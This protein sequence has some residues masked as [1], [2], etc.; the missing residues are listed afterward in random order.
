MQ[1]INFNFRL[2]HSFSVLIYFSFLAFATNVNAQVKTSNDSS[3]S[4]A[5]LITRSTTEVVNPSSDLN[6]PGNY[7]GLKKVEDWSK[8]GQ[9]QVV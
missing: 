9:E 5:S 2:I 1:G 8:M 3:S 6:L 4:E 7:S